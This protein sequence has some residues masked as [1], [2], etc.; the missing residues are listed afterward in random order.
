[1]KGHKRVC[2]SGKHEMSIRQQVCRFGQADCRGAW[3]DPIGSGAMKMLHG[4]RTADITAD[5]KLTVQQTPRRF[6][7]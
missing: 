1:M 4:A 7:G 6:S 2:S 3:T 5:V